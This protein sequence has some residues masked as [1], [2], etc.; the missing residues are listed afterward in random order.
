VKLTDFSRHD[1]PA[2]AAKQLDVRGALRGEQIDHVLEKLDMAALIRRD[3][4]AMRVFL[5]RAVHDLLHRAVVSQM[6]HLAA[7]GLQDATH[8]VDRGVVAVKQRGGGNEP[9]LVGRA[10]LREPGTFG[11]VGHGGSCERRAG[12]EPEATRERKGT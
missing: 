3:R 12:A 11:E 4:D 2:A 10:I 6:D 7:H 9:H 1:H 8:D 5:E